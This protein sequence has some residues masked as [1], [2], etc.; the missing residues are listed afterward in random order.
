MRARLPLWTLLIAVIASSALLPRCAQAGKL[1]LGPILS[2]GRA[3]LGGDVPPENHYEGFM[4]FGGG[5]AFDYYLRDDVAISIQPTFVQKGADLVW[6][7]SKVELARVEFR[8]DYLSIPLALKITQTS[9]N[10]M[11][12]HGG[13]DFNFLLGAERTENGVTENFDNGFKDFEFAASFGVGGL[14]AVGNNYIMIEG[15]YSQG[16]SNISNDDLTPNNDTTSVKNTGLSLIVGWLF[17][18]GGSTP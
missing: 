18:I 3:S 8:S 4:A 15:R 17:Q 6:E 16:L 10:R 7:R 11:Y 9:R 2:A 1:T 5:I 14:I 12:A 13:I